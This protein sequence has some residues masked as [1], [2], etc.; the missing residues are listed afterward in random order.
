MTKKDK[1]LE[2]FL[3]IPKDFTYNELKTMLSGL[4]YKEHQLG[5]TSGSRVLFFNDYIGHEIKIH[6][7]HPGNIIKPYLMKFIYENLKERIL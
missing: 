5:K 3:S 1:L 7:P 2:R 4:G 6:K